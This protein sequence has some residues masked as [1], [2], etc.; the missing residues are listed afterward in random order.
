MTEA[1]YLNLPLFKKEPR[2]Q[3]FLLLKDQITL[4]LEQMA[5]NGLL[6]SSM[7]HVDLLWSLVRNQSVP[8]YSIINSL[9]KNKIVNVQLV[10]KESGVSIPSIIANLDKLERAGISIK[11]HL[12]DLG[13][14][15]TSN[16]AFIYA[17]SDIEMDSIKDF[18]DANY[19]Q[20]S[21]AIPGKKKQCKMCLHVFGQTHDTCPRCN[22]GLFTLI[23]IGGKSR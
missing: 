15:G 6:E 16:R 18:I 2:Y 8:Y 19:R 3:L 12:S 4:T 13:H 7:V 5:V 1:D 23:E 9:F 20:K 22:S 21:K 14:Y 17:L 11:Y 10:K